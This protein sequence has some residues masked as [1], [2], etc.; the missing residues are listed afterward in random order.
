MVYDDGACDKLLPTLM[1]SFK[2][3]RNYADLDNAPWCDGYDP[4]KGLVSRYGDH[5]SIFINCN[6]LPEDWDSSPGGPSL[7]DALKD[8]RDY[9]PFMRQPSEVKS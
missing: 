5:L 1:N 2:F 3:P 8:L 7:K 4:P 9:W 6:W